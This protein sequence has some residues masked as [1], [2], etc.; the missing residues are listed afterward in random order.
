M[1][2]GLNIITRSLF[3]QSLAIKRMGSPSWGV[4]LSP[5]TDEGTVS[6]LRWGAGGCTWALN[7]HMHTQHSLMLA[8][9]H[10]HTHVWCTH[11]CP[12]TPMHFCP[13]MVQLDGANLVKLRHL[14][15][16]GNQMHPITSIMSLVFY[17]LFCLAMPRGMRDLSSPTRD[18]TQAP[19]R[20]SVEP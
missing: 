15:S 1:V 2:Q 7:T 9:T 5:L 8:H 4:C 12:P 3:L 13:D 11:A 19:S 18:G 14:K 17:F 16:I 10:A 6:L 20:G